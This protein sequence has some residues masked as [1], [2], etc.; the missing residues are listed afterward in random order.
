MFN[1]ELKMRLE[2]AIASLRETMYDQF[3][4]IKDHNHKAN[5]D[6]RGEIKE[7]KSELSTARHQ[8]ELSIDE[9]TDNKLVEVDVE[10]L[11]RTHKKMSR[12]PYR[13]MDFSSTGNIILNTDYSVNGTIYLNDD[14]YEVWRNHIL[15]ELSE[16]AW[17]EIPWLSTFKDGIL[18]ADAA[19]KPLLLWTMNGHPLGC[20]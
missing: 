9:L 12:S 16:M 15:P 4:K 2:D 7:I 5:I 3:E 8:L 13:Q 10:Y 11:L 18:A 19:D 17:A 20:T 6:L 1:S 14:N